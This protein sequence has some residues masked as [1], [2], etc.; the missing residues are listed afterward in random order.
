MF[1]HLIKIDNCKCGKS[2]ELSTKKYVV[3]QGAIKELPAV[4]DEFKI[5][6]KV[7]CVF[8]SNTKKA[9]GDRINDALP[10]ADEYVYDV[11]PGKLLH[12]LDSEIYPLR[13]Y[14]VRGEYALA[15]SVGG[16]VITDITRYAA[17][18]A[19]IPLI[20][21]P[22]CASVDG[23]VSNTCAIVLNGMKYS[24]PS[25]APIAVV[26]D[27]DVIA[28]APSFL[29][30]SGVGDMVAKYL[31]IAEWRIGNLTSDE[32]YCDMIANCAI[33]ATNEIVDNIEGIAK[34]E[35]QAISKLIEGLLLSSIAM[36]LA[37]ITRPASSFE[38]QFSHYLEII[39]G[40]GVDENALHGEK[41][42]VGTLIGHANYEAIINAFCSIDENTKNIFSTEYAV[43]K[44]LDKPDHI[45]ELVA[46]ENKTSTSMDL[47]VPL[48]KKNC[49]KVKEIQEKL[50]TYEK[51]LS[52]LKTVGAKT[53]YR[54][55]GL[56]RDMVHR[57]FS[58]CAYI[59]NRYTTLRNVCDYNVFDFS[60]LIIP[61]E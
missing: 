49:S 5:N 52:A 59:R 61:E 34:R 6:G 8:D 16:G 15:I 38:H 60:K 9:A 19:G 47:K 43:S 55:I 22:T 35:P 12:P 58:E 20:T 14:I 39:P 53:T 25:D 28:A 44:F 4:L 13:D 45:K 57:V 3:K 17:Y 37:T 21:V 33:V 30:A 24:A 40:T 54:D 56:T 1:E 26:A 36:Q 18:L 10:D 50:P 23:F 32:Y 11:E 41:V 42:G 48:L 51:L 29:A 31:A 2:H 46:K 27:I 7:L